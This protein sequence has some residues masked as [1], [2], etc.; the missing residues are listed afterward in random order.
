MGN[1]QA[2]IGVD[3]PTAAETI[4]RAK[5]NLT[6]SRQKR[7][8]RSCLL[9]ALSARRFDGAQYWKRSLTTQCSGEIK[10][11]VAQVIG[12]ARFRCAFV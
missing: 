2:M 8:P 6:K 5:G 7:P 10:V 3:P 12:S 4:D 1:V 11:D 9:A